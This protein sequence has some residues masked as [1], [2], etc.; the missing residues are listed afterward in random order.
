MN[1]RPKFNKGDRVI[2]RMLSPHPHTRTPAYLHGKPGEIERFCG[3]FENPEERAI[4]KSGFPLTLLYRVRFFGSI[5]FSINKTCE[6]DF[7]EVEIYEHWLKGDN[8][9]AK[10]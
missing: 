10:S 6:A 9:Y 2:V 3:A 7:V 4:G 8:S 1:A 5:L